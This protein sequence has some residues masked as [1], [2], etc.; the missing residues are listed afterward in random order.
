MAVYYDEAKKSWYCKFR[1]TDWTG[2]SRH[3]TKRGFRTKREAKAYELDF[4]RSVSESPDMTLKSLCDRYIATIKPRQR[5]STVYEKQC[6]YSKHVIPKLGKLP[7]SALTPAV[8]TEWQTYILT[9]VSDGTARADHGKLSALLNFGVKMGWM[10]KNPLATI[11]TI[12]KVVKRNEFWTYEEYQ[13]F[14]EA[15]LHSRS[16]SPK[17]DIEF[18]VLCYDVLFFSGMRLSEFLGLG[19]SDI[20][21]NVIHVR[22]SHHDNFGYTD[23]KNDA[24]RRDIPMPP[25]IMD[26]IREYISWL[27]ERPESRLFCTTERMLRFHMK[28]ASEAAGVPYIMIHGLRHSHVSHLISMGVPVT[29]ISKRVGHASPNITLSVYSH[30]YEADANNVSASLEKIV[31]QML[32]NGK[33]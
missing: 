24:S 11:G 9:Q 25:S 27:P 20:D 26:R 4:K 21:D 6:F 29:V 31:G 22:K 17:K 19:V 2:K 10:Q 1:Y 8:M 15:L 14:R 33:E 18:Y 28:K 30:M 13:R 12:G 23:L 32:V 3:T 5:E 16:K 7:L